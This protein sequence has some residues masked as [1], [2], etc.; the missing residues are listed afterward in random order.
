[1]AR[2]SCPG[3]VPGTHG[4]TRLLRRCGERSRPSRINGLGRPRRYLLIRCVNA[5]DCLESGC[6]PG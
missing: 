6:R 4:Q 3:C 5:R 2:H 1:L